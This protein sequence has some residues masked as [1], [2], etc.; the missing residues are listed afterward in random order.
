LVAGAL[1]TVAAVMLTFLTAATPVWELLAIFAVYGIGFAMV[2]AP[3]TNAA[4][5]GMPPDRAGV[6]GATTSTARQVGSS[7]GIALLGSLAFTGFAAA[8]PGE[9]ATLHLGRATTA[10]I[11]REA[12]S[13]SRSG[14]I[15]R[16]P[17]VTSSPALIRAIGTAFATGQSHAY[18]VAAALMAVC[19]VL[20]ALLMRGGKGPSGMPPAG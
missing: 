13:A 4:V 6:A 14:S 18:L 9:L 20:G 1:M 19:T 7:I 12:A 5:S 17:G 15:A 2:N 3:I 10:R 16:L 11:L 8:L